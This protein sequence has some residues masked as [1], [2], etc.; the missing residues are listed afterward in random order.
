M[1][2]RIIF[3]LYVIA[4][5]SG[6]FALQSCEKDPVDKPVDTTPTNEKPYIMVKG[7]KYY[8]ANQKTLAVSNSSGDTVLNWTGTGVSDT[9]L[10]IKHVAND[11]KVGSYKVDSTAFPDKGSISTDIRWGTN[12]GSL[13][14]NIVKG[15]YELKRENGKFVSYLKNGEAINGTNNKDRYYNIEYRVVWPY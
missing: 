1:K 11:I 6:F 10:K 9:I 12:I 3:P 7:F 4:A 14:L 5:I 13:N 15:T 8:C 2:K